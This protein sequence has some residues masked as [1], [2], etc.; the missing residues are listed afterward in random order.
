MKLQVND[1]FNHGKLKMD[2]DG[3]F[4]VVQDPLEQ[5]MLKFSHYDDD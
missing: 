5:E 4:H 1:M 2:H 3:T